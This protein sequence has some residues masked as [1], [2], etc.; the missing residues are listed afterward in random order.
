MKI[1][2]VADN[3]SS[4][5][6][7]ILICTIYGYITGNHFFAVVNIIPVFIY[8]QYQAAFVS[9][10]RKK[11]VDHY[12]TY[13]NTKSLYAAFGWLLLYGLF[14]I[15]FFLETYPLKFGFIVTV[16]L[17]IFFYYI[18]S[19]LSNSQ[20]VKEYK[21]AFSAV[22][23][24]AFISVFMIFSIGNKITKVAY[25][26]RKTSFSMYDDF[27]LAKGENLRMS[28]KQAGLYVDNKNIERMPIVH[29]LHQG[30]YQK[31]ALK[32]LSNGDHANVYS[33]CADI[34]SN[35][36]KNTYNTVLA[37]T[38]KKT[39]NFII[40]CGLNGNITIPAKWNSQK[41]RNLMG[42]LVVNKYR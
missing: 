13:F 34:D 6:V 28:F 15:L 31:N 5:I 37:T 32:K 29:A 23:I 9:I 39:G 14:Y 42:N 11:D 22:A 4:T 7:S 12:K 21:G 36:R 2:K 10:I 17:L 1:N 27:P 40:F 35:N 3:I 19:L 24:V 30:A 38:D 18:C 33:W 41:Q 25:E 8:L 20:L 26:L 16:Y